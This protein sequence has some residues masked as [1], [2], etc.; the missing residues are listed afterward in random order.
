MG[1]PSDYGPVLN[2]VM[3]FQVVLSTIFIGLRVYTRYFII[4][5]LGWD[6]L[7]MIV[8]LVSWHPLV[9]DSQIAMSISS[10]VSRRITTITFADKLRLPL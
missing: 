10:S 4:R 9:L 7:M 2:G 3:W 8:N 1:K 6:D 5:S